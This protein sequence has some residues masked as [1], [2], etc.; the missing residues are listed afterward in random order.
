MTSF[1]KLGASPGRLVHWVD[2]GGSGVRYRSAGEEEPKTIA[3]QTDVFPGD[4]VLIAS[5]GGDLQDDETGEDGW[6][7]AYF[8]FRGP[9]AQQEAKAKKELLESGSINNDESIRDWNGD[10][11]TTL[12][13]IDDWEEI[14]KID[15]WLP[16]NY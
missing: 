16:D 8:V 6:G 11:Q 13:I 3:S 5:D 15:R 10:G 7:L 9:N 14:T 12:D 2:Q 4:V 1:G